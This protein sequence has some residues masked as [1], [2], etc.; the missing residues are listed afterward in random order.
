MRYKNAQTSTKSAPS[1]NVP[2][3]CPLCDSDPPA[4]VWKYHMLSHWQQ[5]HTDHQL[6]A[7]EQQEWGVSAAEFQQLVSKAGYKADQVEQRKVVLT[8]ESEA[9]L[10][11]D[12]F[13]D[14]VVGKPL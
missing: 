13:W 1:T 8:A 2:Y 14:L 5:M 4:V 9:Q 11:Q 10:Q 6:T 3:E 7:E 12:R